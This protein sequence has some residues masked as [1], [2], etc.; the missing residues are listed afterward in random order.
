MIF[1]LF[2]LAVKIALG[3][4]LAV[5]LYFVVTGVQVWLTGRHDDARSAQAMV[6][7]GAAQYDGVPSPDLAARLNEALLL[8]HQGFTHTIVVTG[9]KEPGDQFTEAEAGGA[10][11]RAHGVPASHIIEVGGSD[12]WQNLA[13]AAPKL[14]ARG[15]TTVL[16]VTDPFHEDR[17]M[18][19][20]SCLGL[21]PFPTPT[22][23]SPITGWASVPYYA[24]EAVGVGLGRIIGFD[25]L[26]RLHVDL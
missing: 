21:K 26:S 1:G 12:S 3:L 6:V 23:T 17:S 2:R 15:D 18:A 24:K 10:Y 20:A 19:I 11:L 22:R 8:F 16:I 13:D 4:V 7:M 25:N 14:I 9:Y 5:L